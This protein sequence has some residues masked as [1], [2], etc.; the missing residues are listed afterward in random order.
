MGLASGANRIAVEIFPIAENHQGP[1]VEAA[2]I[3]KFAGRFDGL[4]NVCASL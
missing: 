3:E 2:F 4:G 1:R